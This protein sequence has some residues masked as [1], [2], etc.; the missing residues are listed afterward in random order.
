MARQT[1]E[2]NMCSTAVTTAASGNSGMRNGT[3]QVLDWED[4]GTLEEFREKEPA[5]VKP[6][7]AEERTEAGGNVERQR[8]RLCV[9]QR[10]AEP[11][12]LGIA[13]ELRLCCPKFEPV[14]VS[15]EQGVEFSNVEYEPQPT[16]ACALGTCQIHNVGSAVVALADVE[17]A[18]LESLYLID[19]QLPSQV[20][21]IS[22]CSVIS[23]TVQI[24]V[25]F[26][27]LP[28][29][30]MHTAADALP[31]RIDEATVLSVFLSTFVREFILAFL[32]PLLCSG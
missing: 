22:A 5:E 7:I 6:Q 28:S 15:F 26:V 30:L 27:I 18:D 2:K 31:G 8:E 29:G 10:Q 17:T 4:T 24:S 21:A 11:Q 32:L 9:A 19:L 13:S 14:G 16:A 25:E 3:G 23:A 12:E 20:N 1:R